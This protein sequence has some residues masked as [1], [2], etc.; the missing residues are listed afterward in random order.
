[1]SWITC[2]VCESRTDDWF[3]FLHKHNTVEQL[4][5]TCWDWAFRLLHTR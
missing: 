1:M 3:W 5:L 4:C 2:K